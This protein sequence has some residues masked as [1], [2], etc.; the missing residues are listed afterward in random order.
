MWMRYVQEKKGR[1]RER[2]GSYLGVAHS[3]RNVKKQGLTVHTQSRRRS[4]SSRQSAVVQN[5]RASRT[6]ERPIA[7]PFVAAIFHPDTPPDHHHSQSSL[8]S[9]YL[10]CSRVPGSLVLESGKSMGTAFLGFHIISKKMPFRAM[11]KLYHNSYKSSHRSLEL[12]LSTQPCSSSLSRRSDNLPPSLTQRL[13]LCSLFNNDTIIEYSSS[14]PKQH[15]LHLS[16]SPPPHYPL[17]G[18]PISSLK[19]LIM[20]CSLS[21]RNSQSCHKISHSSLTATVCRTGPSAGTPVDKES[22]VAHMQPDP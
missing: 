4:S 6:E 7:I 13:P 2:E 19:R 3:C 21:V 8:R 12:F 14:A 15:S 11:Y 18:L 22:H 5:K 10:R 9:A 1:R 16:L 20:F 17:R